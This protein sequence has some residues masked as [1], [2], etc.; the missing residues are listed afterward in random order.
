M[1]ATVYSLNTD[2]DGR[3]GLLVLALF[4]ISI[5]LAFF[6]SL[7]HYYFIRVFTINHYKK[8]TL[9]WWISSTIVRMNK[10]TEST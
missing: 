6:N 2:V 8:I 10:E 5:T 7:I 1:P 4:Q 3:T 9:K